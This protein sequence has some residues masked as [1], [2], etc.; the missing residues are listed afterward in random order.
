MNLLML[1]LCAA[2]ALAVFASSVY[3]VLRYPHTPLPDRLGLTMMA[4]G[5][6]W[7]G[8]NRV[9]GRPFDIGDFLLFAGV[10]VIL[11]RYVRLNPV[12]GGPGKL[13]KL[14]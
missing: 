14:K 10:C 3:I 9:I 1:I 11:L 2:M 12:T 13:P 8:I 4:A 5:V 7:G 6:I